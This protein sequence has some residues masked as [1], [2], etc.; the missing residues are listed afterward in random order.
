MILLALACAG[1]SYGKEEHRVG[2]DGT[3]FGVRVEVLLKGGGSAILIC[4]K[5]DQEP[6]GAIGRGCYLDS[7]D[8][9]ARSDL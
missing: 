3:E 5:Y 8:Y 4:P 6:A 2:S 7:Y 1:C 9:Q